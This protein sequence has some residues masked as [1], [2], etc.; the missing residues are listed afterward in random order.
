MP[1]HGDYLHGCKN[2]LDDSGRIHIR[3]RSAASVRLLYR[4]A[5]LAL[6]SFSLAFV[7]L[8][9][10]LITP[11]FRAATIDVAT[12]H[13]SRD[14]VGISV[15]KLQR[16][17]LVRPLHAEPL[18]IEEQHSL[19]HA[20]QHGQAL[21]ESRGV[22]QQQHK[23]EIEEQ[24]GSHQGDVAL[25]DSFEAQVATP[26]SH[27]QQRVQ[28]RKSGTKQ[29]QQP[30]STP[31]SSINSNQ[32]SGVELT[33]S[34]IGQVDGGQ[35][36][37]SRSKHETP[38]LQESKNPRFPTADEYPAFS[39]G[40]WKF[41]ANT[42]RP[43]VPCCS[44][45]GYFPKIHANMS[46]CTSQTI[47]RWDLRRNPVG[48]KNWCR[49]N[50]NNPETGLPPPPKV[51][52][53]WVWTPN[54]AAKRKPKWDAKLFC[55]LLKDRNMYFLG[56]STTRQTRT[57]LQIMIL[58]GKATCANQLKEWSSDFLVPFKVPSARN[59]ERGHST[60]HYMDPLL[61]STSGAEA[62]V[63]A[64]VGP[65]VNN[66]ED[67]KSV[68][69]WF[70]RYMSENSGVIDHHVD[71]GNGHDDVPTQLTR[72]NGKVKVYWKTSNPSHYTCH[73]R[74]M[75]Q[76]ILSKDA[77]L[78]DGELNSN[79][80]Y[81]HHNNIVKRDRW[82]VEALYPHVTGIIDMTPLY[83]RPDGHTPDCFHSCW[84]QYTGSPIEYFAI[85]ML[86]VLQNPDKRVA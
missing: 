61:K 78:T 67:Y 69:E 70:K 45:D 24:E 60:S 46:Q 41:H 83:L 55:W 28:I 7:V 17:E 42:S 10:S 22:K 58:M 36:T 30:S 56:D 12:S 72:T 40:E 74:S 29:Q 51:Q 86:D 76:P 8:A 64:N 57:A 63:V 31:H 6:V 43:I 68:L 34:S 80:P 85:A 47:Q 1:Q 48:I 75:G 65:H 18:P 38:Q 20:R 5:L 59:P 37:N 13:G 73:G 77:L 4:F 35:V 15:L 21:A 54:D 39:Q 3:A 9:S 84:D 14:T 23:A 66:Q 79:S 81:G 19:R 82:A 26:V 50:H 52:G 25:V 71:Q 2:K 62:I 16:A 49:C 33:S 53:E 11:S 32:S 27:D 44:I